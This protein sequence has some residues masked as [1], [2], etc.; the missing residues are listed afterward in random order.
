MLIIFT[1]TPNEAEAENLATKL[2]EEKLAAC[3]QILP[4]MKSFYFWN[5]QIQ[6]DEEF[7]LLIKTA[8]EKF[9]EIET[10][11]KLNHSYETPEVVAVEADKVST[12]YRQ[13]LNTYLDISN[14]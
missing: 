5:G 6:K 2:V 10:F 11:I 14:V 9:A 13:W 3:V 1:T 8:T 7:L 12:H 4:K